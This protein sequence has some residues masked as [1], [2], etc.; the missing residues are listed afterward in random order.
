MP[1]G[2]QNLRAFLLLSVQPEEREKLITS[3]TW[4]LAA[5][6]DWRWNPACFGQKLNLPLRT[7]AEC[8]HLGFRHQLGMPSSLTVLACVNCRRCHCFALIAGVCFGTLRFRV[9]TPCGELF[10]FRAVSVRSAHEKG[11][12]LSVS[13]PQKFFWFVQ[14][15]MDNLNNGFEQLAVLSIESPHCCRAILKGFQLSQCVPR[16]ADFFG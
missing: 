6:I 3:P 4:A 7:L 11:R 1:A 14:I 16:C 13:R 5:Q 9:P 15:E 8:R 2:P 12:E 10:I